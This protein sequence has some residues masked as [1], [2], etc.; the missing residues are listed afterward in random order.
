V[1]LAGPPVSLALLLG[2]LL[3]LV[4]ETLPCPPLLLLLGVSSGNA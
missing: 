4:P 3:V 2:S 1:F